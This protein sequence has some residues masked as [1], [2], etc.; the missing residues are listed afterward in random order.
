MTSPSER[1]LTVFAPLMSAAGY[2]YRKTG[3]RFR[4]SSPM[5]SYEFSLNFDGRGG[6][7]TVN[8]AFF[9]HHDSLEK[10]FTK[11]LGYA[12]PWCAGGSMLNAG[13]T[14]WKF[15][16]YDERFAS[17]TPRELGGLPSEILHP[18]H[19]IALAAQ[20]LLKC[21]SEYAVPLFHQIVDDRSLFDFYLEYL[22]K[23]RVGRLRPQLENVCYLA[24]LLAGR[25][26]GDAAE[27]LTLA[28]A[29]DGPFKLGSDFERS[30]AAVY[31]HATGVPPPTP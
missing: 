13:A 9:V 17:M 27:V 6:L 11:C 2:L 12:V 18:Q 30:V 28:R 4:R 8:S 26:K 20:S 31:P 3:H 23:G 19:I 22:R 7:V 1:L 16:L 5:G 14:P 21:H 10:E 25:L 29:I 15:P 24:V